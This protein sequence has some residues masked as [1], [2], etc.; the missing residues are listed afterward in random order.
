MIIFSL[1][2]IHLISFNFPN[3]VENLLT[4]N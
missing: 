3:Q 1:P 2:G 4:I